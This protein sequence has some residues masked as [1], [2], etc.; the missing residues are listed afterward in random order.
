MAYLTHRPAAGRVTE[1]FG[2]RPKPTPTSPPIHYGIDYGWGGGDGVYAARSGYVKSYGRDGSY[3]NKL[4]IDHGNGRETWYCHLASLAPGLEV[5]DYVEGGQWVAVMG[6]T[7]NVTAKHLHFEFRINRAAVDPAPYQTEQ[8]D[9]MPEYKDWSQQSKDDLH[10]DLWNGVGDRLRWTNAEG[11]DVRP[12]DLLVGA[13]G[14]AAAAR[15]NSL[16]AADAVTPGVE[17]VKFD[18]ATYALAKHAAQ[19]TPSAGGVELE[20]LADAVLDALAKRIAS[21]RE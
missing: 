19:V 11:L 15:R 10:R 16:V 6:A 13:D 7:G 18:G 1:A 4:V 9:D 8:D 5:G 21:P 2:P 12:I 17:G 20:A 14:H 3:G